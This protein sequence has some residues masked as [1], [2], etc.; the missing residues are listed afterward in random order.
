MPSSPIPSRPLFT[1]HIVDIQYLRRWQGRETWYNIVFLVGGGRT[2]APSAANLLLLSVSHRGGVIALLTPNGVVV[3]AKSQLSPSRAAA[4]ALNY[5][6]P[7][8]CI[9]RT[10]TTSSAMKCE[11][12]VLPWYQKSCVTAAS[13]F[14]TILH[15]LLPRLPPSW[16]PFEFLWQTRHCQCIIPG[17][18][19]GRRPNYKC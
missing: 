19:R 14:S 6:A 12:R 17:V 11:Y 10:I 1:A 9:R 15:M 2:K 5:T 7:L 4:A 3:V 13:K 16:K 8:D 18:R